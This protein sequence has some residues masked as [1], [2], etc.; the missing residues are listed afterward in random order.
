[1]PEPL[2]PSSSQPAAISSAVGKVVADWVGRG[3]DSVRTVVQ[4][5][6]VA[7][8]LRGTFT[9]AELS[10]IAA[11]EGEA[12]RAMRLRYQQTMREELVSVVTTITGR[13]VEAFLSDH[14]IESDVAVETFILAAAP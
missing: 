6:M 7:C 13:E 5:E 2:A 14:D 8:V 11:G 1:M 3:P 4:G 12:I 9:R 10:M